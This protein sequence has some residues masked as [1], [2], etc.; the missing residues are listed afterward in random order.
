[1]S[2]LNRLL[3]RLKHLRKNLLKSLQKKPYQRSLHRN[4]INTFGRNMRAQYSRS[5]RKVR[6]NAGYLNLCQWH[7]FHHSA[8]RHR[9]SL[10]N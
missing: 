5:Q 7:L 2:R 6:R 10:D 8:Y 9:S 4:V 3:L 1:V